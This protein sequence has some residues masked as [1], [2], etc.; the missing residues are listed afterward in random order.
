MDGTQNELPVGMVDARL[1]KGGQS[2]DLEGV[3][4]AS[5]QV[6]G[7]TKYRL[8][9]TSPAGLLCVGYSA[10]VTIHNAAG[11]LPG[12]GSTFEDNVPEG[13]VVYL[14]ELSP[15]DLSPMVGG[16]N[17]IVNVSFYGI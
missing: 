4:Q 12:F 2:V 14:A 9:S 10:P 13:T 16:E 1:R 5:F 8:M 3:E 6:T 11:Y 17:D 7:G 15:L